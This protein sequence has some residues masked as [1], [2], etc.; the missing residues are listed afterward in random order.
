MRVLCRTHLWLRP[1]SYM[2][3]HPR[4]NLRLR[5]NSEL[6]RSGRHAYDGPGA[7]SGSPDTNTG[8]PAGAGKG[9]GVFAQRAHTPRA[10]GRDG[11]QRESD[12]S[13]QLG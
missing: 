9:R 6:R 2:W 4:P 3:L 13:K 11:P 8:S 1:R 7:T 10:S 12:V 5:L